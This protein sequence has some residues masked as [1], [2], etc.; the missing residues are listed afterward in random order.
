MTDGNGTQLG[1]AIGG[2]SSPTWPLID[3]S[4]FPLVYLP[5]LGGVAGRV[6]PRAIPDYTNEAPLRVVLGPQADRFTDDGIR[7]LLEGPY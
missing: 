1:A 2:L 3:G 5:G 4:P 6:E 7:A